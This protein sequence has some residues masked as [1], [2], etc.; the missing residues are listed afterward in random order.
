MLMRLIGE[1]VE[2]GVLT[3]ED[4]PHVHADR[5]QIEQVIVNL[6]VNAR[7]AMP[8]G[9]TLTIETRRVHL[10][11]RYAG[12]HTGVEPG[13]Y[14]CL[15]VTDTGTGIDRETQSRIFEPFFTTKD[16]GPGTGLGLATVHGIVNQS[17]GHWR[18][19]R[20]RASA[21]ASR[22]IS[23]RL[24]VPPVASA[25]GPK[26]RPEQLTGSE[27]V[28]VCEDDE[29]VRLLLETMLTENGYAV[30][31]ASRPR[32]ALRLARRTTARSTSS[33]PTSSCRSCPGPS[34]SSR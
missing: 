2:I 27:T 17:G 7:D 3:A 16:V 18:S 10:D 34:S 13:G 14:A 23:R 19:T 22:C 31:T 33:S 24:L 21:R 15:S 11:E 5:G 28:L 6:V 32:E 30:L 29:M 9:G 20:S 25:L 4:A 12:E 1:N 26:Q 8:E